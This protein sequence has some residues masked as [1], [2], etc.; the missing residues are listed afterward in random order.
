MYARWHDRAGRQREKSGRRGDIPHDQKFP[1]C[2]HLYSS[3]THVAPSN[4]CFSSD[5]TMRGP[6]ALRPLTKPAAPQR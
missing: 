4:F 2:I 3:P 5:C 6:H 1:S